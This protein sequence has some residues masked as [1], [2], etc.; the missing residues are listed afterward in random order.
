MTSKSVRVAG[1]LLCFCTLLTAA[2]PEKQSEKDWVDG[3]WSQTDIGQFLASTIH[4]PAGIIAKGLSI[5]VG[6]QDEATMCYDTRSGLFRA[7]WLGFI[8]PH[9]AR[10]GLIRPPKADNDPAVVAISRAPTDG[11]AFEYSGLRINGKRVVLLWQA[12]GTALRESPWYE[13]QGEVEFFTRAFEIPPGNAINLSLFESDKA[14]AIRQLGKWRGAFTET[15]DGPVGVAWVGDPQAQLEVDDDRVSLRIPVRKQTLSGK[16]I[17]WRAVPSA[18]NSVEAALARL[19]QKTDIAGLSTVG[20]PRWLPELVTRGQLGLNTDI[21]A[22]DTLTVPYD[23]PWKALMFLSGVDFVSKGVAFVSSIHGDVWRVSGID[24]TLQTVRWKRFAT[25]LFQPLGLRVV[26]GKIYVLGRDRITELVD[27]NGDGEADLYRNFCGLIDTSAGG[28]D[29]VACLEVDSAGNFYYVDPRGVHRVSADGKSKETLATGWRNP[30]GLGVG[31]NGIITVAPQQGEWTPSS[32]IYEVKAG[33]YYGF[34]GPRVTADRPAG[35]DEPLCW[36]PH[37]ADNSSGSQVWVSKD[38]WGPLGGQMLHLVWGRCSM[39]LVLRDEASTPTHGAVVP[40]PGRFLSGPMRGSFSDHDG[41]LY[42][43]GCTGWQTS[44]VKD[45]SLQRARYTGKTVYLP[46]DF[47]VESNGVTLNFS[48]P[49]AAATAE[50]IG[51]Y[52]VNQ[53]N[54]KYARE[55]GSDDWSVT[56]PEEKSRDDVEIKSAKLSADGRAVFLEIPTLRPVMEMEIKYNVDAADGKKMRGVM[57]T[58]IHPKGGQL[59]ASAGK[60]PL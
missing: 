21:L 44:A 41:H 47:H 6:E 10:F 36:I 48:Q 37:S 9:P 13:K 35:Y 52:A 2:E 26:N 50:D 54:Y 56:N 8:K 16:L 58:T 17:M 28:H 33:A 49:L 4:L 43:V 20:S 59:S 7:A 55:Y 51:S 34:G 5:R 57:Y 12:G 3:R 42:V 29:Y 39:M 27:E 19:D 11:T 23:N 30:N 60:R 18:A 38:Q 25:G 22:V 14:P 15:D 45:G 24:E 31:P 53:W 46:T 32:A 40:L 1:V